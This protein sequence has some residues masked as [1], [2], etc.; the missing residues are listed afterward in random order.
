[1]PASSYMPPSPPLVAAGPSRLV[2]RQPP[3][4]HRR[5]SSVSNRPHSCCA[6][7]DT[8]PPLLCFYSA[9]GRRAEYCNERVCVCVSVCLSVHDHIF[10]TTR[11]IFINFL[12]MLPMAVAR[13]SCAGVVIRYVLPCL[14]MTSYLLA[15]QGCSTSTPS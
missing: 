7:T 9:L 2:L 12:C 1:M 10:G 3:N 15:S 6:R 11:P 14:C 8:L 5:P 4:T 13:F